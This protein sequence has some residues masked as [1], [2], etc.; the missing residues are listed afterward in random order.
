M[1]VDRGT[2]PD[3][4]G[5]RGHGPHHRRKHVQGGDGMGTVPA[6]P[7]PRARSSR[8][9]SPWPRDS[10]RA[11]PTANHLNHGHTV[12]A[13]VKSDGAV[14]LFRKQ[15]VDTVKRKTTEKIG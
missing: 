3:D 7:T 4:L 1:V 10:R 11:S 9:G 14:N 15:E 6:L 8:C 13:F 2:S 5:K 12:I